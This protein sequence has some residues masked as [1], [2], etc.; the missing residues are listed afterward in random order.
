M[1]DQNSTQLGFSISQ[2][3]K[4]EESLNKDDLMIISRKKK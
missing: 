4:L 2:L 3:P 1:S